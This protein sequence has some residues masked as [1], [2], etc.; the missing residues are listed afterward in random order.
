MS[1]NFL[2]RVQGI[3]N[4][5]ELP[6]LPTL[7]GLEEEGVIFGP[8]CQIWNVPKKWSHLTTLFL[9]IRKLSQVFNGF[10]NISMLKNS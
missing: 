7:I 2:P 9:H 10:K 4:S 5:M 6:L 1:L 3:A 8:K